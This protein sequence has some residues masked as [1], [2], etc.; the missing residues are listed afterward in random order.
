M[1]G[2]I[3]SRHHANLLRMNTEFVHW[4]SPL[5]VEKL[6]YILH[7]AAYQRQINEGAGILLG[8]AHN[9]NYPNH[10]NLAWLRGHLSNFFYIDRIIID[11]AAHGQG[12][13]YKL[14]EDVAAFARTQGYK[15]LACEVN[16]RPNNPASH[17]FHLKLGFKAIGDASY[18][19]Y[20]A[21]L[22]YYTKPI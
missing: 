21:A 18:P 13:G 6:H 19:D 5:D 4:L 11:R 17:A 2:P 15:W 3:E 20:D 7:R 16:T 1:I 10:K 9:V 8:Y 22:R 14:Y 12:L